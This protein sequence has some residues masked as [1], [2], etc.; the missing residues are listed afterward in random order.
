[1]IRAALPLALVAA[2]LLCA[3]ASSREPDLETL[4][5]VVRKGETLWSISSR[6]GTTVDAIAVANRLAD[7]TQIRVGERLF[8]PP[9]SRAALSPSADVW[10]RSDPRGRAAAPRLDWPVRGDVT[11]GYGMRNGAHHDG[12]DIPARPG[13]PIRASEAGRVVHSDAALAGYGNMIILKH[14]GRLS[15]V[16][17][18]NRRNLVRVGEFVQKGQLIAEV[19]QTGR[20]SASHLHFEVRSDGRARN[21]LDYLR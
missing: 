19:G 20:T 13:T 1:M 8:I 2:L 18:H 4:S 9:R 17:A 21:P 14:A 16:Y 10:T 12:I 6:Y 15:T 11:S 7:P 5:H 3:C